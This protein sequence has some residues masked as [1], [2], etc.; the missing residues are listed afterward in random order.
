MLDDHRTND[1]AGKLV[2]RTA[3]LFQE[4]LV[5][6]FFN[7]LPVKSISKLDPSVLFEQILQLVATSS[8]EHFV[9]FAIL[10]FLY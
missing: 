4:S 5:V 2:K 3:T 10:D 6:F 7:R 9:Y 1:H 8:G